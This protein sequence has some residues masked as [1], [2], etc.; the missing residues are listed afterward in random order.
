MIWR[1]IP[2]SR[3]DS[4]PAVADLIDAFEGPAALCRSDGVVV[5]AN[6]AWLDWPGSPARLPKADAGLFV[7][8]R[9]ARRAGRGEA[10]VR[11]GG[12][13]HPVT[14]TPAG[15]AHFLVRLPPAALEHPPARAPTAPPPA[16]LDA[17]A[18]G[19]PFGAA[20]VEGED[21][22][23]G[24]IVEANEALADIAGPL[25]TVGA[26]LDRLLSAAS[27][28]EARAA[29]QQARAGPFEVAPAVAPERTTHLYLAGAAP[30]WTAY[31]L[32]VTEQKAIQLQLAQRNKM[33][34]IGH[35]AG[36]VAH[37]F[38]NLLSAISLRADELLL[39]H[40]LGDPA[41]DNLAEIRGTV[42]RAAGVANQLLTYSRKA[43][44][45]RENLDLG[46]VLSNLEVLLRRLLREDVRI[47]L[48]TG[49][50]I[51]RV[52]A[53]KAQIE[54]AIINLVVNAGDAVRG[55]GGGLIRLSAARL[56]ADGR[57]RA[58]LPRPAAGRARPDR[59]RRRRPRHRLGG[60]RQH[61]RAVLH[62]QAA[63]RRHRPRPGDG[64]WHRQTVRW[65]DRRQFAT[66]LRRHV[67]NFST[68]ACSAAGH[69]AA[70]ASRPAASGA[71]RP[72]RRRPDPVR[73]GRGGGAGHR[74]AP[75]APAGL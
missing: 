47:E 74:R 6:R 28:L 55:Q 39:R 64:L 19:A 65:L 54:N 17:F 73:G 10:R 5:R 31:L 35:L 4:D 67:P 52:R 66:R 14:V 60:H 25:A 34:A 42:D 40:P 50:D 45:R 70:G 57:R 11:L 71:A 8:F 69:R 15:G 56:T 2:T 46:E 33:E 16:A 22:F 13:D 21:P 38:N 75:A 12:Q 61:L 49:R 1:A 3:S 44:L 20:L 30:R 72:V 58:G 62:H 68:G 32:D 18:A 48:H 59:G 7:A 41:Y 23:G 37:D 9:Q 24:A 36:G 29:M 26:R 27:V 53:D 43:T 51:P 63:R